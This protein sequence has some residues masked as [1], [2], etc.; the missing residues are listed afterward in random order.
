MKVG[1]LQHDD[2][3]LENSSRW[4]CH[5]P[6]EHL[7]ERG[8]DVELVRLPTAAAIMGAMAP[9]DVIVTELPMSLEVQGRAVAGWIKQ[10]KVV[11][12]IFDDAYHVLPDESGVWGKRSLARSTERGRTV[13]VVGT[14]VFKLE[15]VCQVCDAVVVPTQSLSEHWGLIA[16]NV[17]VVPNRM[18]NRY[19]KRLWEYKGEVPIVGYGGSSYHSVALPETGVVET[20]AMLAGH[21]IKVQIVGLLD[22]VRKI[23]TMGGDA[24]FIEWCASYDDW[25]DTISKWTLGLAPLHGEYDSYRSWIKVLE[26]AS[27]GI[28][29]VATA[30]YPYEDCRGG[31]M[32]ENTQA[33]WFKTIWE[34]LTSEH[35]LR[36]YSTVGFD[37]AMRNAIEHHSEWDRVMD[38]AKKKLKERRG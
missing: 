4:L 28:P 12:A 9:Y 38:W 18:P 31:I 5:W 35:D 25:R 19:M 6:V 33:L 17:F 22:I 37:W 34:L 2:P 32:V 23:N 20:L 7:K 13:D 1:F 10:G 24:E 26:Y 36:M 15:M 21:G 8:Y 30:D 16:Q 14:A 3:R 27:L 11:I 29:W